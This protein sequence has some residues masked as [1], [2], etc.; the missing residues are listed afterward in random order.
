MVRKRTNCYA[1]SLIGMIL[2]VIIYGMITNKVLDKSYRKRK[3]GNLTTE[4]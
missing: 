4:I 3:T 1:V 2:L